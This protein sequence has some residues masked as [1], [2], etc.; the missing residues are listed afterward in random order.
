MVRPIV[1]QDRTLRP[2][3]V[4][5]QTS[6]RHSAPESQITIVDFLKSLLDIRQQIVTPL[7]HV[8]IQPRRRQKSKKRSAATK[9]VRH[10]NVTDLRRAI[11]TDLRRVIVVARHR[12]IGP[13][14]VNVTGRRRN[15]VGGRRTQ[16]HTKPNP[17]RKLPRNRVPTHPQMKR[18]VSRRNFSTRRS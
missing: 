5:A 10:E 11:V 2:I 8:N 7:C 18:N 3:R 14:L 16:R 6:C 1:R 15:Q 12:A 13:Y 9:R 17:S 4:S